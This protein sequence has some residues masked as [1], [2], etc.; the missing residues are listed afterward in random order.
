[1]DSN[2]KDKDKE[3]S[4]KPS[5]SGLIIAFEILMLFLII[6]FSVFKK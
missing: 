3:E 2:N 4:Q 5:S 6:V 1:M